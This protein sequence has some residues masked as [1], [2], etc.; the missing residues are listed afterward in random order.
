MPLGLRPLLLFSNT[1]VRKKIIWKEKCSRGSFIR[2]GVQNYL[3]FAVVCTQ[4]HFLSNPVSPIKQN[5]YCYGFLTN[6]MTCTFKKYFNYIKLLSNLQSL[7]MSSSTNIEF[8]LYARWLNT[9][10]DSLQISFVHQYICNVSLCTNCMSIWMYGR[11]IY[12]CVVVCFVC[13]KE[14]KGSVLLDPSQ[15]CLPVCIVICRVRNCKLFPPECLQLCSAIRQSSMNGIS[16][17]LFQLLTE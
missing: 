5:E 12:V 15:P 8:M 10:S 9:M 3:V 7:L 11:C 14:T 6:I 4:S 13:V 17:L 16:F 2:A 1:G